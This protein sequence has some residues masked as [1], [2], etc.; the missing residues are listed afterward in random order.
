MNKVLKSKKTI[1]I[2]MASSLIAT[3]LVAKPVMEKI[4]AY[5]NNQVVYELDG[6]Q[7]LKGTNTVNYK[8]KNYVSVAELS[9]ALG[10]EVRFE[11]NKVIITTPTDEKPELPQVTDKITIAKAVIKDVNI[12]SNRVTILPS[13]KQ[14]IRENYIELNVGDDTV[15]KLQDQ[16]NKR[17]YGIADLEKG[18]EVKV[19]HASIM[20]LS[21][22]PQTSAYE[23]EILTEK[24]NNVPDKEDDEVN[25]KEYE[26]EGAII[27]EINHSQ[28]YIV[29]TYKEKEYKASYTNKTKIEFEHGTKNPNINSLKVGQKVD[30][31]IEKGIVAEIEVKK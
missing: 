7:I 17:R 4:H 27:K 12:E 26:L 24:N 18:M 8:D 13:G 29:V 11:G 20:T 1:A 2:V 31:E 25:E 9:K 6:N 3:P 23:I 19:V 10:K 16:L 5:L 22:P 30:I 28:K 14:D 21:L 15:V